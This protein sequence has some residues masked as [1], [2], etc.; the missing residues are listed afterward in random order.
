[1]IKTKKFLL[2]V[3]LVVILSFITSATAMATSPAPQSMTIVVLNAPIDLE[4]CIVHDVDLGSLSNSRVSSR[5]WETYYRFYLSDESAGYW[6]DEYITILASSEKYGE[7]EITF[8][9]PGRDFSLKLDLETQTFS[10]P[11]THVRNL[12][13]ALCWLIPL[14]IIDSIVFLSFGYRQKRSWMI[15][16]IENLAMQVLFIGV[17]S[18]YHITFS[19]IFILILFLFIPLLLIPGVRC[20]KLVLEIIVFRNK[21]TEKSMIRST[22]CAIVMN[23]IGTFVVILLGINLPLPAL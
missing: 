9:V 1:M 3:K 6:H 12:F 15:F 17:W 14:F 7:F 16:S 5:L 2:V 13:I 10:Q 23:M 19:N 22:S 20:C 8:P 21:I 4:I 18:L 11:Y